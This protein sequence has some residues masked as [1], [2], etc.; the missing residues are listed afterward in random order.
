MAQ[1]RDKSHIRTSEE[2]VSEPNISELMLVAFLIVVEWSD[3]YC[4]EEE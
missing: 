4:A 2:K 3:E 1:I